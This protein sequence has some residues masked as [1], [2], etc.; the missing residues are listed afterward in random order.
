MAD[1][2]IKGAGITEKLG[3]KCSSASQA[4]SNPSS[5]ASWHWAM[6]SW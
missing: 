3:L 6:V 1:A 5:S 4:A 2:I